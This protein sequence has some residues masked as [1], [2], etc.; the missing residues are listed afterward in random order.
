MQLPIYTLLCLSL[1][2]AAVGQQPSPTPAIREEVTVTAA[3]AETRIG[4]TPASVGVV[5]RSAIETSA[6]RVSV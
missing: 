3:G 1:A 6:A 4:D 5:T 2:V